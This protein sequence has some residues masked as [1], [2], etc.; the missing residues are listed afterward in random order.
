VSDQ[1]R[2]YIAHEHAGNILRTPGLKES[3]FVEADNNFFPLIYARLVERMRED[4]VIYDRLDLVFK[5]PYVGDQSRTFYGDWK[6]LRSLLEK[7]IIKK[8]RSKGVFFAVFDKGSISLPPSYELVPYCLLHRAVLMDGA[9]TPYRIPNLWSYYA[10][11]SFYDP[12]EADFMSRQVKAHFF[13]R[14]G[15]YLFSSGNS[16]PARRY[17]MQASRVGY[18]DEGIHSMAATIFMK[19]GLFDLAREELDKASQS[20]AK[21]AI[22][23]NNWG[24][25]YFRQGDYESAITSFKRAIEADRS[26]RVYYMN[27]SLALKKAGREEEAEAALREAGIVHPDSLQPAGVGR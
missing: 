14:Y 9:G 15:E 13:I 7:E 11:E 3:L 8:T 6:G 10:S 12:L 25:Y 17:V 18:D 21:P 16:E 1:S 19:E 4:V 20:G 22:M 23:H 26:G 5:T 2:N 24:C 27:L